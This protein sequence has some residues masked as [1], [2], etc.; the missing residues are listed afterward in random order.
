MSELL[1]L[2]SIC[3]KA[4]E[5][6]NFTSGN[7]TTSIS[8]NAPHPHFAR[9]SDTSD[10]FSRTTFVSLHAQCPPV[11]Q[12][13]SDSVN[14]GD[15]TTSF[16]SDKKASSLAALLAPLSNSYVDSAGSEQNTV[17]TPKNGSDTEHGYEARGYGYEHE[18]SHC[19][20]GDSAQI[21]ETAAPKPY[22]D[23]ALKFLALDSL[24]S[25]SRYSR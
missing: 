17:V 7:H 6:T 19:S 15:A 21:R 14:I 22:K 9:L 2:S 12:V 23:D 5:W 10:N 16:T 3:R 20:G 18:V 24:L 11:P 1:G 8:V 13:Y 25:L 4:L